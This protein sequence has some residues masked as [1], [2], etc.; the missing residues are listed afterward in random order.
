MICW[1]PVTRV[2]KSTAVIIARGDVVQPEF[3]IG[4]AQAFELVAHLQ[5]RARRGRP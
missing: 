2:K 1:C 5:T 4:D 3:V